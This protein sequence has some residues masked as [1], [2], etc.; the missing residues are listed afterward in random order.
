MQS[1]HDLTDLFRTFSGN[2]S[3]CIC[4]DNG[5]RSWTYSYAE[6]SAAAIRFAERLSKAGIA[7]GDRVLFWS[8]NR[9]EWIAAFWGCILRGAVIVPIDYRQSLRFLQRVQA[10]VNARLL[11]AGSEVEVARDESLPVW[12]L[13]GFDWQETTLKRPEITAG[14]DDVAEIVFTSGATGDPRGVPITHRNIVSDLFSVQEIICRYRRWFRPVFPLRFLS[15]IP[16]SH[17]FGQAITLFILPLIP[18]EAVFMRGYSPHEMLRQIRTHHISVIV[19][20]PKILEI[21]RAQVMAELSS[22][23]S[24][25]SL[26]LPWLLRWWGHRRLHLSLGWKFWAFI[27]GGAPLSKELEEFWSGLGFAVIEGYG[28]TETAPIIS[29]NNPFDITSGTV[30]KP[31]SGVTVRIAADGEILV[32]GQNVAKGY[33]N[34]PEDS[35][36][37][38]AG[39][40]FHTGDLGSFDK[41]GNLIVRGRKKELI[42]T[43][44]GLKIIPDDVEAVLE[45]IPGVREA[46]VVGKNRV[47]AVLVLDQGVDADEVIRTAN[48][49]LE[50]YQ[51]IREFSL[52]ANGPLPRTAGTEKLRR[53]DI[54]VWVDTGHAPET[55]SHPENLIDILKKYAPG[56]T[57]KPDTTLEEL[58]L[59]SLDRAQLMV[60]LEQQ[61]DISIDESLLTTAQTVSSLSE[62]ARPSAAEQ[63]P[64]W[65]R[66]WLSRAIR[67]FFLWALWLPVTRLIAHTK[68]T[69]L[70]HVSALKGP[71]IFTPNHQSHLDTPVILSALP[72]RYRFHVAAAMWKEYFDPHFSPRRYPWYKWLSS[73]LLYWL[74]VLFFDGFPVPQSEVGARQSM[75]YIGDLISNDWSILFFP[76]G[77]RTEAGEI[78]P[79]QPGIGLLARELQVPIVPI[80][81]RG[82]DKVL[83]RNARWPHPGRVEV[84][85]GSPLIKFEGEDYIELAKRVESAVKAL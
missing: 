19:A 75:R 69:G 66:R 38:F 25:S 47:H 78:H 20:V 51:K 13:S 36:T 41:T 67:D 79:F 7:K 58:G 42:V 61:L 37:A 60:D 11:L 3:E 10:T 35:A 31:I 16:L 12:R 44:D 1:W 9:P 5:Y 76:E 22:D 2:R 82:V 15:L 65:S 74:V 72:W 55:G 48:A 4:Y 81:L 33:F 21:L 64:L 34:A 27:V 14:P 32:R 50:D 57:I 46:A 49:R 53:H 70:E 39:G 62:I 77:E 45:R 28:L 73:T 18:A 43:P 54:Q 17:M 23:G 24:S 29:F 85:F 52:W 80:R 59:S 6:M 56:R 83:H 30:G 63:F 8:E 26:K 71:V 68:I 84:A 40:W